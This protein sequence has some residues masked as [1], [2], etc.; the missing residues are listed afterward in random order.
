MEKL[1]IANMLGFTTIEEMELFHDVCE[2]FCINQF[3]SKQE[4]LKIIEEFGLQDILIKFQ[5]MSKEERM[6]SNLHEKTG[7]LLEAINVE[8]SES[9]NSI[10]SSILKQTLQLQDYNFERLE[11]SSNLNK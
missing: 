7:A 1:Q 10:I 4:C 5:N 3:L 9:I 8:D 2:D 11:Q 6:A